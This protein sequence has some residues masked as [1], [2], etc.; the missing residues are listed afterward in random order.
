MPF[1]F[2]MVSRMNSVMASGEYWRFRRF[3][4]SRFKA[5]SSGSAM[6]TFSWTAYGRFGRLGITVRM[7][8]VAD[9]HYAL[10]QFDWLMANAHRFDVVVIGGDLL[11]LGSA[12]GADQVSPVLT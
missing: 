6:E 11:D 8:F 4:V 1:R 5:R 10:K 9:P 12:P 3:W 2:A 7:L